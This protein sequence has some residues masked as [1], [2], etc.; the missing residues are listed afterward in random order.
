[1]QAAYSGK[2]GGQLHGRLAVDDDAPCAA[3][4]IVEE[5]DNG[6]PEIGIPEVLAG[7]QK[8][9]C[10]QRCLARG[11]GHRDGGRQHKQSE[12]DADGRCQTPGYGYSTCQRQRG[13]SL[14]DP[15]LA[16]S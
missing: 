11:L 13:V 6:A 10:G 12:A 16:S 4:A 7:N 14:E 3:F 5:Q 9:A 15:H 8:P 2:N 1:M